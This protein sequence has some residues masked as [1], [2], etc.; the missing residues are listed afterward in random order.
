M[1]PG[2]TDRQWP[3]FS[4]RTHPYGLA[5]TYVFIKQSGPPCHCDLRSPASAED[6]RHPFSRS[7]GANLPSS[8]ARGSPD[9][10]W[11]SHPGTP[12][13]VLGTDVGD[14]SQP[15]FQGLRGSAEPPKGGPSRLHP[16]LAITAL[17]GLQRLGGAAAPLSLP[18]S[19]RGWA[20]VAAIVPP[21]HRNI[22]RFPFRWVRVTPHLRTG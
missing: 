2:F 17:P 22:N 5:G 18:R 1:D 8:L 12:V 21:R 20:C 3:G 19:V 6:P 7:Y 16:V 14:P 9:T 15:P 10:P 11:A 13:S 4:P